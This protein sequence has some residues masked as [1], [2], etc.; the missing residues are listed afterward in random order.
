[1]IQSE[2]TL[3][4]SRCK[5]FIERLKILFYEQK[6]DLDV[7]YCKFD[8]H[9]DFDHRLKGTYQQIDKN[10]PWGKDWERVW[11]H[12]TGSVPSDWQNQHVVARVNLGGES[13]V[14]DDKGVP[15]TGLSVHT[16]WPTEEF[17]RDIIHITNKSKGNEKIDFWIESTAGQIYGLFPL[18]NDYEI[19]LSKEGHYHA[20][21]QYA[22]LVIF[23]KDIWDLYLDFLVLYDLMLV[24][25]D[26]NVRRKRILRT[27]GIAIDQFT[28][29][30]N[31]TINAQNILK[32]ELDKTSSSSD[33]QTQ[34]IGHAHLDTAWLWTIDETIRKCGRTFSTQIDLLERYPNYH[35]GA[36]QAQLYDFTKQHYPA[37]Y[38]KIKEKIKQGRWEVQG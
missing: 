18:K 30:K 10:I 13:L 33:L 22:E 24:L 3:F 36:S 31:T 11:F 1:M 9:V 25:P 16:L 27:L 38:Q 19:D 17:W 26:G 2:I 6:T 5:N 21:V 7:L 20:L 35:F 28:G 14:F 29:D 23:R 15:I 12:I 37:L 34:A 32:V 8:P 4:E